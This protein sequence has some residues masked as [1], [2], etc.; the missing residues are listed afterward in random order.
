MFLLGT[1]EM[2]CQWRLERDNSLINPMAINYLSMDDKNEAIT[3]YTLPSS[4]CRSYQSKYML[5]ISNAYFQLITWFLL[6]IKGD[7]DFSNF[8]N[9]FRKSLYEVM[10]F[11]FLNEIR[12]TMSHFHT[13]IICLEFQRIISPIGIPLQLLWI[14]ILVMEN[15]EVPKCRQKQF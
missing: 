11:D 2:F 3:T 9:Q 12:K 13:T 8:S 7:F 15:W 14:T 5:S 6:F 4:L 1:I 10:V